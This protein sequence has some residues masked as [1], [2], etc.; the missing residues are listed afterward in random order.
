MKYIL[1]FKKGSFG[2]DFHTYKDKGSDHASLKPSLMTL[3]EINK[4]IAIILEESNSSMKGFDILFA[5]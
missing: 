4:E 3:E 5:E 2:Y 1:R